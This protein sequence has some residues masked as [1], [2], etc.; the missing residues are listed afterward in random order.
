MLG[1]PLRK[2]VAGVR[3][4]FE[5]P[6]L[7]TSFGT[8]VGNMAWREGSMLDAG[9]EGLNGEGGT[10]TESEATIGTPFPLMAPLS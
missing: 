5:E 10:M 1:L 2:P 8:P 9:G 6:P 7:R 4:M 3:A